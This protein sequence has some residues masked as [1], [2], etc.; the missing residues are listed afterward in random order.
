VTSEGNAASRRRS[1]SVGAGLRAEGAANASGTPQCAPEQKK[2]ARTNS[3]NVMKRRG[4]TGRRK[5]EFTKL[6]NLSTQSDN[7]FYAGWA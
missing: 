5:D 3:T 1:K 4:S 2:V 7:G 6:A